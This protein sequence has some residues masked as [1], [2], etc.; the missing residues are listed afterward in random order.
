MFEYLITKYPKSDVLDFGYVG[1][2]ELAF[3][4]GDYP[5]AL[6]L[7][8][9]AV[10]DI[11]SSYRIKEATIGKAK[12]L[13]ALNRLDEAAKLY[14]QIASVKEWRGE[15]TAQALVAL[16]DIEEKRGD[17]AKA[18]AYYQRV[19]VAWQRYPKWVAKA[20]IE[21]AHAFE[22]LGKSQ[23]ALNTYKEMVRNEKISGSTEVEEA[24]KR[25]TELGQG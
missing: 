18:I 2:G 20:Y 10:D 11:P 23:E 15:A 22:K 14:E 21:S 6:E 16:G 19:Y 9:K 1:L 12:T 13:A 17:E 24:K 4:A 25:L 5:K 7:F 3:K 8:S